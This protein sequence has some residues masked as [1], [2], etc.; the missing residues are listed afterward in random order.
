MNVA[1]LLLPFVVA[2]PPGA[3]AP[4]PG[5][6]PAAARV[7]TLDRE[8]GFALV[9]LPARGVAPALR[10]LRSAPGVRYVE[11]DA[12]L[13]LA[14][15]GGCDPVGRD[16]QAPYPRWRAAIHLSTRSAAGVV[17]G[18]ADS[19]VDDDRL[20]PRQ[21]PLLHRS[22]GGKASPHD[23]TG[24]G[25]AVASLLV[26]NRP[27]VGVVGMVPDATL[28]SARIVRSSSSC[29]PSIL[30]HGLLE[31]FGCLRRQGAQVVNVSANVRRSHALVDSLRAL[32]LS[33]ALVVA[34]AG[35]GG[36]KPS[37]TFPASEP[38]VLGVG[39]LE[40]G[41]SEQVW[42]KSTRGPLVDLVA[43]AA[44]IKVVAS[45]AAGVSPHFETAITP[46][47]TSFSTPLVT[48]A[49]AMVWAT[50]RDWTA[51][52]VASALVRSA[53][54]L[55]KGVPSVNWGYGRLNVSLALRT[56]R[57]PESHEPNDWVAAALAQRSLRP[58]SVVIASLGWAGDRV[59]AY[60]VDMPA[61]KRGRAVIRRGGR[62][63]TMRV[64]P[65][66][67]TDPKLTAVAGMRSHVSQVA[68]HG[69]RS[70]LVVARSQ[71]AGAYTLALS[72]ASGT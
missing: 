44:G 50:H 57:L 56:R 7:A 5:S 40:P 68:L 43:P 59:D 11:R 62:G 53:T 13:A 63:L 52:D 48:A 17:I 72:G 1:A 45:G 37:A 29:T 61:G 42:R 19:G 55:G 71:G 67:T 54:P 36:I 2:L 33:G 35:N 14:A 34:A 18:I 22:A 32:Q 30:E 8:L 16:P 51:S 38:G 69:G 27:D 6:L 58:G 70:L 21:A 65:I 46:P 28:V 60:V 24:H 47:G 39:A 49:A 10:R 41:S 3:S 4:P 64:L 15:E 66:H 26:A 20:A 25:T 9:R 31:A 23:P 12:P